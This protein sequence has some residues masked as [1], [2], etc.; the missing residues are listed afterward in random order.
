MGSWLFVCFLTSLVFLRDLEGRTLL[1]PLRCDRKPKPKVDRGEDGK[2]RILDPGDGITKVGG[3]GEKKA[4][5]KE[6]QDK[7][8]DE[9]DKSSDEKDR[10]GAEKEKS[11]AA[12]KAK[13]GSL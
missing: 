7:G 1:N 11:P 4:A 13:E 12:D 2:V 3:G 5:K 9:K 6:G 10:N 8:G